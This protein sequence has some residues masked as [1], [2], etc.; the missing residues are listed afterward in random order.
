M[1]KLLESICSA[2]S[3]WKTGWVQGCV[4][5]DTATSDLLFIK[6][7]G[8]ERSILR[9]IALVPH[10][11]VTCHSFLI[12]FLI[13]S[14]C[15]THCQKLPL[16]CALTSIPDKWPGHP[17]LSLPSSKNRFRSEGWRV[18]LKMFFSVFV[19]LMLRSSC[20][21]KI[22]S[23]LCMS[24]SDASSQAPSPY[25]LCLLH[26]VL[27]TLQVQSILWTLP[28]KSPMKNAL[29]R[30]WK[31]LLWPENSLRC[32]SQDPKAHHSTEGNSPKRWGT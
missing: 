23:R 19:D 3:I 1:N 20:Y 14:S 4:L 8:C 29:T 18:H 32:L 26:T 24:T 7:H 13:L 31:V 15:H 2:L 11:G 30:W 21:R 16:S 5:Q 10:E 28:W 6:S 27:I 25:T 17:T 9:S 22:L 12:A